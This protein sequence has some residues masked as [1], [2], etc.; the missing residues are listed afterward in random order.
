MS[1]GLILSQSAIRTTQYLILKD[2]LI[3]RNEYLFSKGAEGS[4]VLCSAGR[5]PFAFQ[6]KLACKHRTV[7]RCIGMDTINVHFM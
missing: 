5:R 3:T 2:L 7:Y 1:K 4:T 6:E